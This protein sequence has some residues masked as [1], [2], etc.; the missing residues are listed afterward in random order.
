MSDAPRRDV[1]ALHLEQLA[2]GELSP[3][4][5]DAVLARLGDAA[6]LRV[7][8]LRAA[9]AEI[10]AAHPPKRVAAEIERRAAPRPRPA[11]ALW[12]GA[13]ALLAAAALA[14]VLWPEGQVRIDEPAAEPA[15][16][17]RA[18]P[19][20]T[21][22][23]G[24]EPRLVLHR[25]EGERAALLEAPAKAR[26]RDVLQVSY[27]AGGAAH[28]VV[29]S[30]D[31]GGVVT[32]HHPQRASDSTALAQDGAIR[33]PQSYE[34][35]DAPGFERFVFVTADAELSPASVVAA[36]RSVAATKD[37]AARPLALPAGWRQT[38]FLV[39]KLP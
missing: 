17:V 32:L 38:S 22:I 4:Q 1:P 26:A 35:D 24:L 13:P 3:A 23:K 33:L 28:G 6:E 9:D 19:G 37:A 27:V 2:L 14:L 36:A 39:E 5:R 11:R 7:A 31:G 21:R 34:L 12:L 20:E 15:T 10:L 18:E 30:L 8:A 25:Q 16:F 29:V